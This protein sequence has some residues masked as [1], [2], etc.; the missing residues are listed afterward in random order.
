MRNSGGDGIEW[1]IVHASEDRP[2][3]A[4]STGTTNGTGSQTIPAEA[5]AAKLSEVAVEPGDMISLVIGPKGSHICD[6]TII[7]LVI[8]EV[9]G[10]GRVWNL[11]DDV[12]KTLHAGNPH[13]DGQGN[14]DVWHF[15]AENPL[16]L[17][18]PPF[19]LGLVGHECGGVHRRN[20]RPRTCS[21]IRQRI[22]GT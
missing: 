3:N 16:A 2:Q 22:R 9:G 13:A 20:S 19:S 15:Y 17:S 10:Q 18:E 4:G 7:D 14:A 11:T 1:S 6:T 8:T 5:D 12:V 21:T